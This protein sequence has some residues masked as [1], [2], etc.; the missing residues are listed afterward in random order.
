LQLIIGFSGLAGAGKTTAANYFVKRGFKKDAYA[1]VMKQAVSHLFS[2]PME[3]LLGNAEQKNQVDLF[4]GLSYRQIL[5]RFGTEACR[6]TF[7]DDFWEKVM[8]S[9]H[10]DMDYDLV[11][12]DV[13]FPNEAEAILKRGG[14]VIDIIRP[15]I[16]Q[17]NH[18]S[19]IPLPESLFTHRV[20]NDGTI[21]SLH[22]T[23]KCLMEINLLWKKH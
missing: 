18:A 6:H 23:L 1:R 8:W 16:E 19:E 11:I 5:Q 20:I 22:H 15:G 21:K 17:M 10:R 2:I 12:D 9:N 7:G 4:W 13:R 14:I 3:K